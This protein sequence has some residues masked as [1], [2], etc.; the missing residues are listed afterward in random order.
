MTTLRIALLQIAF[1]GDAQAKGER[2]CREARAGGADIALFPEMWN[3]GYRLP[4]VGSD[5]AA[6]AAQAVT[7]DSDF[8]RHFADLA[9]ELDMLTC[10]YV[11]S[12]ADA[13]I[14]RKEL[15]S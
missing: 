4:E 12:E 5:P 15:A 9:R 8:V 14:Y 3:I 11:F 7:A 13:A 6:L 2:S 1:D 10:P